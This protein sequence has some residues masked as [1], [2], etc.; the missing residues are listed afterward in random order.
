MVISSLLANLSSIGF[1]V[2]LQCWRNPY[3]KKRH[4]VKSHMNYNT[5]LPPT[6]PSSETLTNS[7]QSCV[8]RESVD[9]A[10]PHPGFCSKEVETNV[11]G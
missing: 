1:I 10:T 2:M 4:S 6:G 7:L 3:S 9:S 8:H 11:F 5:G